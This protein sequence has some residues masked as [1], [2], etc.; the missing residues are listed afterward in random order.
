VPRV[1]LLDWSAINIDPLVDEAQAIAGQSD[2]ALDKVLR[3]IQWVVKYDDV[4]PPD[5]PVRQE[6]VPARVTAI[7]E[8]VDKHV[9]ANQQ[10]LFHGTG[11]NG[12]CLYQK[13]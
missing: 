13:G 3:G 6:A 8:F 9:I 4:A 7:A 11:R 2:H 10:C 12:E 5:L 1:G